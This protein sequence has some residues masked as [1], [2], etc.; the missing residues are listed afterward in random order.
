VSIRFLSN[1]V[2]LIKWPILIS[3]AQLAAQALVALAGG[4]AAAIGVLSQLAGVAAALPGLLSAVAQGIGSVL[5]AASG[6]GKALKAMGTEAIKGGGAASGGANKAAQ[7]LKRQQEATERVEDA[8]RNLARTERDAARDIEDA[9]ERIVEATRDVERA[10]DDAARGVEDANRRVMDSTRALA[11][12]EED[13]AERVEDATRRVED[14]KRSLIDAQEDATRAQEDLTRARER[15]AQRLEDLQL[16]TRQL[17]VDESQALRDVQRAQDLLNRNQGSSNRQILVD[18]LEEA[19]IALERIRLEQR[20]AGDE[21]DEF[22]QKGVDGAEEVQSAEE[23][24]ADTLERIADAERRVQEAAENRTDAQVEGTERVEDA[25][26]SLAEAQRDFARAQVDA[27]DRIREA[28]ERLVDA[29]ENAADTQIEAQERIEDAQR[30]LARAIQDSTEAMEDFGSTGGGAMSAVA[31]AMAALPKSAQDFVKFLFSLKPLLDD[32]KKTAADNLFPGLTAGIK[33]SLTLFP[34]FKQAVGETAFVIGDLARRFGE[35]VAA[36]AFAS[37]IQRLLSQNTKTISQF[38]DAGLI[39]ADA[40]R[41]IMV[42]AIPLV[43][44]IGRLAIRFAEATRTFAETNRENGKLGEFFGTTLPNL[45]NRL[46]AITGNLLT[47]FFN[48]GKA[49]SDLGN[50]LLASFEKITAG[51]AKATGSVAGQTK[52]KDFFDSLRPTLTSIG[53]LIEDVAKAFARLS[54][55]KNTAKLIDQLR[56]QLL[57]A[58]EKLFNAA[59]TGFSPAFIDTISQLTRLFADLIDKSGALTLLVQGIG[60]LAKGI[61]TLVEKVPGLGQFL[62]I[63]TAINAVGLGLKLAA[64]AASALKASTAVTIL[65]S[66]FSGLRII[67]GILAIALGAPI[68]VIVAVGVAVAALAFLVVKNWD[69]IKEWTKKVWDF[70]KEHIDTIIRVVLGIVTG[71]LSEIV[72]FVVRNWDNIK[73]KTSAIWNGIRDFL[74]GLWN[75]I[76]SGASAVFQA[77]VQ[78]ITDRFNAARNMV[79]SVWNDIRGFL[80]N[81]W[82]SIR[83]TVSNAARNVVD[84]LGN[85]W[86]NARNAVTN[87]WNSIR[88]AVS[89]AIRGLLDT[90]RSIPGSILSALGDL[91]GLLYNKGKDIVQGLINGVRS[92]GRALVNAILN[93]IPGP[94][95]DVVSNALGIRSPSTVF[96]EFG[97]NLIEG[98][99]LGVG[100]KQRSLLTEL[101]HMADQVARTQ[102]QLPDIQAN[103]AANGT[104]TGVGRNGGAMQFG[105]V[106]IVIQD[107]NNPQRTAQAVVNA[108][109]GKADPMTRRTLVKEL[110]GAQ[111]AYVRK[112]D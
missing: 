4:A 106:S 25:Q 31:Q 22:S 56:T 66:V 40:L 105:S 59:S 91:A 101:S 62:A 53:A 21:M 65:T 71:G 17:A 52:L 44:F 13:A 109:Q 32:L 16:R 3:G 33:S 78:F 11:R 29:R 26:R 83:D 5:L 79:T 86:N 37:D 81:I 98:L 99:I 89:N 7:A 8:T 48:I 12:A 19:E 82:N 76:K 104:A 72:L 108:L 43:D 61:A 95:R 100:Q 88:D 38:G 63:F 41:H 107:S 112:D 97:R 96:Q 93:L 46:L 47:T 67:L 73:A 45:I 42:A 85:A 24:L 6:I 30:N 50:D 69:T 64:F 2:R 87:A 110:T 36:P 10:K 34:I 58:L 49:G 15:A 23:R 68:G 77:I 90:V 51:W 84:T 9:N 20:R 75:N 54:E 28:E 103:I 35:M 102:L 27:A 18:Q 1:A 55:N 57:P 74:S 111:S 80:G 39:L 14:A 94:V 70:V 92:M 60:K